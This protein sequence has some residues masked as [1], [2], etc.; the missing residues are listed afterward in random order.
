MGGWLIVNV[1]WPPADSALETFSVPL[2]QA[3][4]ARFFERTG[5]RGFRLELGAPRIGFVTPIEAEASCGPSRD[6]ERW[7]WL[8]L[9]VSVDPG[10]GLGSAQSGGHT[11]SPGERREIGF[12]D[13]TLATLYLGRSRR[14]LSTCSW[15]LESSP[16]ETWV[17]VVE[18]WSP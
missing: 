12:A 4:N 5:A 1:Y 16:V 2:G 8:P 15:D 7:P 17:E 11:L 9:E 13:G 14:F 3:K 18:S 10:L 6:T